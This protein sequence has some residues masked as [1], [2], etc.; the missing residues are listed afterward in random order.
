M[1]PPVAALVPMKIHSERVPGKNLR[2]LC[3]KPLFYWILT[4]LTNSQHIIKTFINTDSEQIASAVSSHFD[5]EIIERPD[6][7]KGD[8][9]VAN[10][11]ISHDLSQIQNFEFF[12]QTHVTNPL[13][14]SKTI[15]H[16]I[17][18]FFEQP[19]FD[20]LMS[21]TSIQTRLYWQDGRPL[22]HEV[23]KLIR[24]Q[25]LAPLYEENSC[26]YIFSRDSFKKHSN[27][28]GDK[29]NLFIMDPI[30]AWDIDEELDFLISDFLMQMRLDL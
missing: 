30:E 21:V 5:V 29:P 22:N 4:A 28:I 12:L 1:F 2:D 11:L 20:S 10:Q 18:A 7:L 3:G 16:A 9:V 26:I 6:E 24:T 17:E 13:L 14:R 15:D 25:D 19:E 27:R 23:N 8:M